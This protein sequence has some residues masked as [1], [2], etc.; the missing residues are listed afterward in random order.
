MRLF[1]LGA[2]REEHLNRWKEYIAED[3]EDLGWSVIHWPATGITVEEVLDEV[4]RFKPNIFL[5]SRSHNHNPTGNYGEMLRRIEDMGIVT[6]SQHMD[7]YWRVKH[8][9]HQIGRDPWWS[10][11]Y[12]FTADGGH[13]DKFK[14]RGV[15]HF[16]M[17]P[18]IG[19]RVVENVIPR[20]DRYKGQMVFVGGNW[21]A[22][23]GSHRKQ[24]LSWAR[25]QN[26]RPFYHHRNM[27]GSNLGELY[28]SCDFAIG[29]SAQSP[30]GYYW[31]D[32]VVNTLGRRCVLAHPVTKGFNACGFTDETMIK[33]QWYRFPEILEKR[34]QMSD[35]DIENMR[36]AGWDVVRRRHTYKNR[37]T[38]IQKVVGLA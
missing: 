2:P 21:P 26:E 13:Q 32:R 35:K 38:Q 27:W 12:V 22:A 11:Q 3:A 25:W 34:K 30:N 28:A 36:D 8:R 15:N 10:A 16:W 14:E 37:L 4:K 31:S 20:N 6:V 7:M 23:H 19:S 18:A 9:A 29:E 17:P 33:Y 5:W 1:L 24:L